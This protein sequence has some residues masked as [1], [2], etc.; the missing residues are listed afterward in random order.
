MNTLKHFHASFAPVPDRMPPAETLIMYGLAAAMAVTI[1][2]TLCRYA[3]HCTMNTTGSALRGLLRNTIRHAPGFSRPVGNLTSRH[4]N[5]GI[6][7]KSSSDKY[8]RT[9][10]VLGAIKRPMG[11]LKRVS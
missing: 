6:P 4:R 10:T 9:N 11:S 7:G 5:G 2:G 1:G 8:R 3:A